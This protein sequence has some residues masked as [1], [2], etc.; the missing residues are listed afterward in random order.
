MNDHRC[1]YSSSSR[2]SKSL[3]R[4]DHVSTAALFRLQICSRTPSWSLDCPRSWGVHV[5]ITSHRDCWSCCY[6]CRGCSSCAFAVALLFCFIPVVAVIAASV[7]AAP[8]S[9]CWSHDLCECACVFIFVSCDLACRGQDEVWR[10][11]GWSV[12]A[13]CRL[14]LASFMSGIRRVLCERQN[15]LDDS[16]TYPVQDRGAH[17]QAAMH[18]IVSVLACAMMIDLSESFGRTDCPQGFEDS[19]CKP[20]CRIHERLLCCLCQLEHSDD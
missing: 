6:C 10:L 11:L 9:S 1:R 7:A 18:S 19:R 20:S 2:R 5:P 14:Y 4:V 16:C 13:G 8:C 17:V 3:S 15:E 12:N